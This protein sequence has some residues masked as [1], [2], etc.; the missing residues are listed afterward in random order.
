MYE[1]SIICIYSIA[2]YRR[3]A[4]DHIDGLSKVA[5]QIKIDTGA[6]FLDAGDMV[7][8]LLSKN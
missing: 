5:S 3:S 1:I 7:E 2:R 8:I 6:F 4:D